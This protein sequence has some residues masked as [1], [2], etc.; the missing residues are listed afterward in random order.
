MH[1]LR[2]CNP[3]DHSDTADITVEQLVQSGV[4]IITEGEHEGDDFEY[5][6]PVDM[7]QTL[8]RRFEGGPTAEVLVDRSII[9]E[10]GP[11]IWI[12]VGGLCV[13]RLTNLGDVVINDRRP[14]ARVP[15]PKAEDIDA[16][17]R[18]MQDDDNE[19]HEALD[20]IIS[21]DQ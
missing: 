2:F 15:E 10:D 8:D 3:H 20:R 21:T 1:L 6:G 7:S 18:S 12:N 16:V 11:T 17:R 19:G 14:T 9:R 5:V 4:P 13:A